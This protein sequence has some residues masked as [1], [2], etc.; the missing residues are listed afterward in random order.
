MDGEEQDELGMDTRCC[1]ISYLALVTPGLVELEAVT[2][3][4]D[5]GQYYIASH[6]FKVVD[7][8]L[9]SMHPHKASH[10]LYSMDWTLETSD[11]I[12]VEGCQCYGEQLRITRSTRFARCVDL[13]HATLG[14]CMGLFYGVELQYAQNFLGIMRRDH[15]AIHIYMG[16]E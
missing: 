1:Y 9:L 2:R 7:S 13:G 8:W 5:R 3:Y 6:G 16:S 4:I 10:S 15:V 12:I 11:S 14:F